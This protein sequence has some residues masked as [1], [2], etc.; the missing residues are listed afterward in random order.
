MEQPI[1][2]Y[3]GFQEGFGSRPGIELWNLVR[4]LG[5]HPAGSTLSRQTIE[6]LGGRLPT[7]EEGKAELYIARFYVYG[8]ATVRACL[9]PVADLARLYDTAVAYDDELQVMAKYGL[10]HDDAR[11][12]VEDMAE[13]KAREETEAHAAETYDVGCL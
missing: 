12:F 8:L 5:E 9:P 3:R 11:A 2:T 1:A 4:P 6:S 7:A 13:L 10:S